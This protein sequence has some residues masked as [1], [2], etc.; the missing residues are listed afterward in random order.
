LP[1][2]PASADPAALDRAYLLHPFTNLKRHQEAGPLVIERGQG[3]FV[4][5]QNGKEYLEALAGLWCTA[6]GYSEPR[7]VEAACEQM[8]QL[9]FAHGFGHRSHL[10]GIA[11]AERLV[12]IAP[13]PMSKVFFANSGSEANDTAVKLVWAFNNA[14]GRPHK[15]KIIA[16]RGAYH[17]VTVCSGS[18]TGLSRFHQD[19]DLPLDRFL[20]TECPHFY[21]YAE[22]GEDEDAFSTRLAQALERLIIAEGPETIAAFFAEP[23]MGA[24]GVIVPPAG[25]FEKIQEV[26]RRYDILL[27]VDE[28]ICGFGRTGHLWGSQAFSL[29]PDI[30]TAAKALSSAYLPI[31]AVWINEPIYQALEAL[32]ERNGLFGHGFT[33]SGHPVAA[34][35]ALEATRIYSERDIVGHV[36]RMAPLFQG[37]LRRF[38]RHPLVGEV[39]G[40]GLLAGIELVADKE[41]RRP[42]DPAAGVGATVV[43]IAQKYGLL[44][45]ALGDTIAVCPPLIISEAEIDSLCLRL[46]RTLAEAEWVIARD[47]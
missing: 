10:P 15:K 42:F 27:V 13:V 26:L 43:A 3:V 29:K 8:R 21:R 11:L 34:A 35:V 7:L 17:G 9:P 23:V 1:I 33:Y 32:S 47:I 40:L 38:S 22:S 20:H 31:S 14:L 19:F 25:Y 28:V 45:R 36:R 44:T 6:L 18:L 30:M 24:G 2:N 37:G 12:G 4:Y 39:R 46:E 41:T 5:D 16:R